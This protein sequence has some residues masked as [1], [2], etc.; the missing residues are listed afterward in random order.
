MAPR[1]SCEFPAR[2]FLKHEPKM[3][4]DYCVAEFLW[5]SVKGKQ[6]RRFQ[7]ETSVFK[8]PWLSGEG[9][10]GSLRARFSIVA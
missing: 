5:R 2:S 4:D 1:L 10:L 9:A 3:T 8:F 6:L 7:S